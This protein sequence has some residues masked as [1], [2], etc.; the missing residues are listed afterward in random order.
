MK[1]LFDGRGLEVTHSFGGVDVFRL[2]ILRALLQVADP[3]ISFT[4]LS[5]FLHPRHAKA[6]REFQTPRSDL[7]H[8]W[9]R[10]QWL[11][12]LG[13]PAAWLAGE[14][15]LLFTAEPPLDLPTRARAVTCCHDL[16]FLHRPQFLSPRIAGGLRR[17]FDRALPRVDLWLCNSE[18]TRNDL[19]NTLG[20]PRGR[21]ATAHLGVSP[22][23]LE[24][25]HDPEAIA[26]VR[27]RYGLAERPYFLF[28]GSLEPKK[29]AATLL[30]AFALALKSGLRADLAI[31]GRISWAAPEIEELARSTPALRE[32]V[33]LLGF[34]PTDD[35]PALTAG[36]RAL[37]LPSRYEGFGLPIVEAM[38]AGRPVICSNRTAL[39]EIAGGAAML[40]DPDD[41]EMLAEHLLGL[42]A[43]DKLWEC[44]HMASLDRAAEFSWN[45]CA[46]EA[47]AAFRTALELP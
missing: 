33:H 19:V 3:D 26:E 4:V 27:S 17:A 9:C 39:P 22:R 6:M 34:V 14:H 25:M 28:V 41:P 10:P 21:T 37:S 13:V 15:D 45:R 44:M 36:A 47:L 40:H 29:N 42:A 7:R 11:D 23:F 35:L 8:W 16:M 46:R 43:D 1:I 38:A 20:V 12:R 32:H 18:H 24:A 30:A 5:A 2:E 31:G